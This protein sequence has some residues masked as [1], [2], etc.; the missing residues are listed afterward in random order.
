[1]RLLSHYPPYLK[2]CGSQVK[3]SI[4]GK[5]ETSHLFLKSVKKEVLPRVQLT[6][7]YGVTTVVDKEIATDVSYLDLRPLTRAQTIYLSL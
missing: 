6:F 3:P 2:S 4:T 1:M 5:R 7:Y